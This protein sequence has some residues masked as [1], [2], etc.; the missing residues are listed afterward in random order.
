MHYNALLFIVFK[1]Q[2]K[3]FRSE[4][5]SHRKAGIQ[6][7]RCRDIAWCFC[8]NFFGFCTKNKKRCR[9]F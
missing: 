8:T 7:K 3:D 9:R 5:E 1:V 4:A 6:I 2:E